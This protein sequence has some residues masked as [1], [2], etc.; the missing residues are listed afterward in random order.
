MLSSGPRSF[1]SCFFLIHALVGAKETCPLRNCG[2]GGSTDPLA[3]TRPA[4]ESQQPCDEEMT[5]FSV[6]YSPGHFV[7]MKCDSVA[8][9][10]CSL[11][12][13]L[14]SCVGQFFTQ[15]CW[16]HSGGDATSKPNI[17]FCDE[18]CG[19]GVCDTPGTQCATRFA[20]CNPWWA[21]GAPPP[22]SFLQK[23]RG[24]QRLHTSTKS[25]QAMS[26]NRR[27]EAWRSE[28]TA[29][30][31]AALAS[32]APAASYPETVSF[33]ASR[34]DCQSG[35]LPPK[36][37]DPKTLLWV[38]RGYIALD[39]DAC[40]GSSFSHNCYCWDEFKRLRGQDS[41]MSEM[42]C[43]HECKWGGCEG[44]TCSANQPAP[45]TAAPAATEPAQQIRI[46]NTMPVVME[47]LDSL[48]Y[49]T[50]IVR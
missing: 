34:F 33:V 49:K 16:C 1:L 30:T 28:S 36:T 8:C 21:C 50:E 46:E 35:A 6:S 44:K 4:Y 22:T 40:E 14:S 12:C 18:S 39:R 48:G 41:L 23:G 11:L 7:C 3:D 37:R 43:D 10:G 19:G 42:K 31:E 20:A 47:A 9:P 26:M 17:V 24:A 15:E 29:K 27:M 32:A 2:V 25:Q 45:P 38:E 5:N 13:D